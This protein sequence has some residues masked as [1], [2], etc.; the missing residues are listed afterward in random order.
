MAVLDRLASF[1]GEST[2]GTLSNPFRHG[3]LPE[4][5]QT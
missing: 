5:G 2:G 4:E 1:T 3:S